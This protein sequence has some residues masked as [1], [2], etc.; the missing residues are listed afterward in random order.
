MISR[1]TLIACFGAAIFATA[2][3]P[4]DAAGNGNA[5]GGGNGNGGSNGNGGGNGNG[6]GGGNGNGNGGVNG[7]GNNGGSNN[8]K[9][10]SNGKGVGPDSPGKGQTKTQDESVAPHAAPA[11]VDRDAVYRVKHNN[12][13]RETLSKGRYVLQDNRG[14]TVVNRAARPNDYARLRKLSRPES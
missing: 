8:G 2:A 6:N 12:G 5:N 4:V 14:R 7:N 11:V 10:P 1:R 3:T 9:G 13:F